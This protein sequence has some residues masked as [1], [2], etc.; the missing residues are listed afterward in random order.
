M[1]VAPGVV[2]GIGEVMVSF[3]KYLGGE[4]RLGGEPFLRD[5]GDFETQNFL[6]LLG[7]DH[8]LPRFERGSGGRFTFLAM[9]VPIA[10]LVAFRSVCVWCA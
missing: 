9:S 8:A 5:I 6:G 2:G 4:S 7:D 10:F 1:D 3:A